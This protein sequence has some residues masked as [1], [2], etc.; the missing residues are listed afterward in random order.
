MHLQ[1]AHYDKYDYHLRI[2]TIAKQY[3]FLAVCVVGV[4]VNS[5]NHLKYVSVQNFYGSK[6]WWTTQVSLKM[7]QRTGRSTGHGMRTVI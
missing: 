3:F 4:C 6:I 5:W 2:E 7:L 1:F